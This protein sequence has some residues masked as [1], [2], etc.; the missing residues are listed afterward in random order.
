VTLRAGDRF[1]IV[2]PKGALVR[3]YAGKRFI[4]R[5]VVRQTI[6]GYDSS[7]DL[8]QL[9]VFVGAID[10]KGKEVLHALPLEWCVKLTDPQGACQDRDTAMKD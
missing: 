5:K 4:C 10:D 2:A 9:V 6:K 3:A 8:G 7:L 1:Q